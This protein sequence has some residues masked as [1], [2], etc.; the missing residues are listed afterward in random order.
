MLLV[1]GDVMRSFWY[2]VFSIITIGRGPINTKSRLCQSSGFFIQYGTETSG[3]QQ[4]QHTAYSSNTLSDYAVLVIAIH[5]ALQ[6]FRPAARGTSDGLFDYRSY[7]FSAGFVLPGILAGLAFLNPGPAYESLGAFCQLPIRPF[8]YRNALSWIPRYIIGIVIIAL[9][10]SIY[11]YVGCEFRSY[12]NLSQSIQTPITTTLGLSRRDGDAETA[13]TDLESQVTECATIHAR[14]AS[15]VAHDV[16]SS[17]HKEQAVAFGPTTYLT[18]PSTPEM[19][20]NTQSFPENPT[21]VPLR[22]TASARPRPHVI[23]SGNAMKPSPSILGLQ[24]PLSPH[25][26]PIEDP[27]S[28]ATPVPPIS[29]TDTT[30]DRHDPNSTSPTERRLRSQ[31]RRVRQQLRLLFVYP[32]VYTLMWLIPFIQHSMNYSDYWARNPLFLIRLGQILCF[33]SMGFIDSVIFSLREKPWR[34]IHSSDGTIL[35]SL[36]VWRT[37]QSSLAETTSTR[38]GSGRG[39]GS[40]GNERS[41]TESRVE[42]VRN[43]VRTNASNDYTRM[44][45]GRARERLGLE[46]VER[47]AEWRARSDKGKEKV[48]ESG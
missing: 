6:I 47:L 48:V 41:I 40:I 24:D 11:A 43:S 1:Y 10:G 32:L 3:E 17:Q 14:R 21:D 16:V 19:C 37:S 38:R 30:S 28:N 34:S 42:R 36:A 20:T 35:G 46:K 5:G 9:A 7:I 33:A 13:D 22:L 39:N 2:F 45:A 26:Q 25:S 23:R 15:S 12:A 31:R 18:T 29:L 27:L 44:A 8:W 4:P